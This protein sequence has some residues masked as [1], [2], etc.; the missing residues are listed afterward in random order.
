MSS[1][2][3]DAKQNKRL[4]KCT[5][6]CARAAAAYDV[7]EQHMPVNTRVLGCTTVVPLQMMMIHMVPHPPVSPLLTFFSSADSAERNWAM[8]DTCWSGVAAPCRRSSFLGRGAAAVTG[9]ASSST[10][11]SNAASHTA[12]FE[13]IVCMGFGCLVED[14]SVRSNRQGMRDG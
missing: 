12:A 8:A 9:L 3:S 5:A 4:H 11:H 6:F 13:D 7:P 1:D 2:A 10:A 14:G